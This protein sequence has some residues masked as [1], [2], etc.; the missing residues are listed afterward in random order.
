M[1]RNGRLYST[2]TFE[3]K[4][5]FGDSINVA[6]IFRRGKWGENL[7]SL[8]LHASEIQGVNSGTPAEKLVAN[9]FGFRE[10]NLLLTHDGFR[11][12]QEK[13]ET[14]EDAEALIE[15][16]QRIMLEPWWKENFHEEQKKRFVPGRSDNG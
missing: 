13:M 9:T 8:R 7:I 2:S 15:L 14:V 3:S 12:A 11:L 10:L 5:H 1:I 6:T 16:G 4:L